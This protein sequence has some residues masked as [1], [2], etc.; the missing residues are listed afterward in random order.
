M[1]N[2]KEYQKDDTPCAK[3]LTYFEERQTLSRIIKANMGLE[4]AQV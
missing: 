4:W 3:N 1:I 2:I